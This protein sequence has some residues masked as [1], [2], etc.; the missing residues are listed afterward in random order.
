MILYFSGCAY[1]PEKAFKET[2]IMLSYYNSIKKP[3]KR[4]RKIHR[5]RIKQ[6]KKN[7]KMRN[8]K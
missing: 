7:R 8:Y 4:F 6:L 3:E 2:N 1:P 5:K